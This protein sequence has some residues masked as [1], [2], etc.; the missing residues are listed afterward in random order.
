ML[1]AVERPGA[2][3]SERSLKSALRYSG[4]TPFAWLGGVMVTRR[5]G[6][7]SVRVRVDAARCDVPLCPG[8][9]VF[10]PERTQ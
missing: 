1:G 2:L 9:I 10:V 8:D 7:S 6:G 3:A 4:V 5:R